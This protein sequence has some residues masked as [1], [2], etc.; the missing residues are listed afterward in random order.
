MDIFR[1]VEHETVKENGVSGNVITTV[2]VCV[3]LV[4][5]LSNRQPA[6]SQCCAC[7][8][9]HERQAVS[10]GVTNF[11]FRNARPAEKENVYRIQYLVNDAWRGGC[12]YP[13]IHRPGAKRKLETHEAQQ[14]NRQK[15]DSVQI[16]NVNQ[17]W[18]SPAHMHQP[19]AL[20]H[21]TRVK[22]LPRW[23]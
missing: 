20:M 22:H 3:V 17:V 23:R 12:M 8:L 9:D 1:F 15:S 5:V 4:V 11:F 18:A 13:S 19:N 21:A 10:Y 6:I 14:Q 16:T 2:T 7:D